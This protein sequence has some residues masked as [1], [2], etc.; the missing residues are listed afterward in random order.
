MIPATVNMDI[1]S[2]SDFCFNWGKQCEINLEITTSGQRQRM[3][4]LFNPAVKLFDANLYEILLRESTF[5][6]SDGSTPTREAFLRI[7]SDIE[8]ILIRATYHSIT[9]YTSLR[10]LRMDTAVPEVTNLGRAP[11]VESCRCPEGYRGLSCEECAVGY[12]KDTNN[13]CI[14]CSCNG[15]ASACDP[16]TGVCL[17]CQDNTEGERCERCATGY[18]GDSTTGTPN[19]CRPCPC[20]LTV[21]SNQCD[22]DRGYTGNPTEVGGRCQRDGKLPVMSGPFNV[23]WSRIDGQDLPNR[24]KVG[25]RYSLTIRDVQE[26][27]AGRYVCTA[28]N[29]HGSNIQYVNLIVL[30]WCAG[31][32][33]VR[34]E[35]GGTY[36]CT[37]SDM[38]SM[39]TDRATLRVSAQQVQPT[40]R[41]EPTFQ[42]V[43]EFET[44]EFRCVTTGRPAPTVEWRRGTGT[45]N[46]SAVIS[47]DVLRISAAL[48]SDEAQYFC[49]ASNV[50]G[51]T[52][53][54][55]ILYVKS[56]K[57]S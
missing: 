55:T 52:E 34:P 22:T 14:R 13:R 53:V 31:H 25:P 45:M 57:Y 28:T 46:P 21:P 18:Y 50:A 26:T 48:R 30:G 15:H 17:N 19:D 27:D 12:L 56:S 20:P 36:E 29:V 47:G 3:Y 24:A 35:D 39:D 2:E 32:S 38:F 11:M 37:G 16:A 40:V 33:N 10:D 8:A 42:T 44:A 49:K 9:S 23:I 1:F 4:H 43:N 41:I 51:T 5:Q 6:L 54:R 7:L